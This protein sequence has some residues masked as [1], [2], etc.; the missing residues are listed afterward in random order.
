MFK[1]RGKN[2][3]EGRNATGGNEDPLANKM[4]F[5]SIGQGPSDRGR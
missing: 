3:K 5:E 1:K 2:L 4:G